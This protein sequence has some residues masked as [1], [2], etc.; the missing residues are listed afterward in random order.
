MKYTKEKNDA[1]TELLQFHRPSLASV[2]QL[3]DGIAQSQ[4]KDVG[5]V[6]PQLYDPKKNIITNC[7]T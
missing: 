3:H 7:I 1:L 2:F 4:Q 5:L 6:V